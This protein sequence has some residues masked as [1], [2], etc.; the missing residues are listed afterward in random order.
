[1]NRITL[2]GSVLTLALGA[3]SYDPHS[4]NGDEI[5]A[6]NMD[7]LF[8]LD[9]ATDHAN[10]DAISQQLGDLTASLTGIDGQLPSLHVGV[11][12][13]D[14]GVSATNGAGG[15]AVG[16]CTG[17]G[18]GGKLQ[19]FTS[20]ATDAYLSDERGGTKNF[21]GDLAA[22]LELL[23]A[24]TT[25]TG[26]CEYGQPLEAMR[27]AL[28]ETVNPGFVR[29]DAQLQVVF[30]TNNDDCSLA[31]ADFL[32]DSSITGDPA[33]RC[34]AAGVVCDPDDATTPGKKRNCHP[35]EDSNKIVPVGDYVDFLDGLKDQRSDI[36][37]SA[38]AGLPS[39]VEVSGFGTLTSCTGN[40]GATPAVR[41]GTLVSEFGGTVVDS[42][43]P[44]NAYKQIGGAISARDTLCVPTTDVER[45][46]VKDTSSGATLSK[47]A[48]AT[49][50][51]P[52]WLADTGSGQCGGDQ[53]AIRAKRGTAP[54]TADSHIQARCFIN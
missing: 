35:R 52:C 21:T 32:T 7:V 19:K 28:D 20:T 50:A 27:Q 29:D 17:T 30:L 14:L 54:A 46:E 53:T 9:D 25:A 40:G 12:T 24:P 47:C 2:L 4:Y 31:S 51:G 41:T 15:A 33:L 22:E 43:N 18:K 49:D 6:R 44:T 42:C 1:M 8:V 34:F 23:T 38:V 39:A 48:S 36:T 5:G 3:C 13:T 11:V 26:G 45:C 10:Y 16:A 37:V